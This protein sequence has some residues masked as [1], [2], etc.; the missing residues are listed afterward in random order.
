VRFIV[1]PSASKVYE[2]RF[3]AGWVGGIKKFF[4]YATLI[5]L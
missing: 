3:S 5:L 4:L 2:T 1:I